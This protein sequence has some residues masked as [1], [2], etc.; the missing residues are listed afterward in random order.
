MSKATLSVALLAVMGAASAPARAV[1][2]GQDCREP[3]RP[4]P[5]QGV[6]RM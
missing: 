2:S 5:R 3:A 6:P 1:P 4:P